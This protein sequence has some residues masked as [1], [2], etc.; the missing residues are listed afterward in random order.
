MALG[1]QLGAVTDGWGRAGR[2]DWA[3]VAEIAPNS[4]CDSVRAARLVHAVAVEPLGDVL[5]RPQDVLQGAGA[6]RGFQA[7]LDAGLRI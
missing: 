4:E 1:V 7:T 5:L 6:P 3:A 2:A